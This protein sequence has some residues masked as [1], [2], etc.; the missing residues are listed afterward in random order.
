MCYDLDVLADLVTTIQ[1]Q[2]SYLEIRTDLPSTDLV[3]SLY[4][5]DEFR[6]E[7]ALDVSPTDRLRQ[8]EPP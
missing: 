4:V 7:R 2:F 3:M 5:R 6:E 8:F 1:R